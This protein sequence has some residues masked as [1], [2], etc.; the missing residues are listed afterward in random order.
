MIDY[1]VW[2]VSVANTITAQNTFPGFESRA[3]SHAGARPLSEESGRGWKIVVT[4]VTRALNLQRRLT[5]LAEMSR[6]Q[7]IAVDKLIEAA[8]R[9][10]WGAYGVNGLSLLNLREDDAK[11]RSRK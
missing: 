2:L 11:N 8:I 10:H 5:I 7:L 9:V 1:M 6:K 4:Y 3:S